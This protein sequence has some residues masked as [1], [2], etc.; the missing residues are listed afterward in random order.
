MPQASR[1]HMPGYELPDV[2]GGEGLLPF[3]WAESRLARSRSYWV[4]TTRPD[5]APHA[6]PVW[7]V[8]LAER[9]WFST[10]PDSRKARNLARDG[11]C[12]IS[13]E[14]A[15]EA[16][17]VEG[18]AVEVRDPERLRAFAAAYRAKYDWDLADVR[19]GIHAVRPTRAFG[20]IE[21]P[22]RFAATATR[23]TFA[24]PG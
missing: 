14:D 17:I 3:G 10:G 21:H 6:M 13:T 5:G 7:G 2:A 19:E 11:R 22:S 9:F 15:R 23:W 24:E 12:V 4:S 8:W 18:V 1:P 20:F 16:V